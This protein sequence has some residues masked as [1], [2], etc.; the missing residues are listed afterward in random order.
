M[1]KISI[2]V[3]LGFFLFIEKGR[4]LFLVIYSHRRLFRRHLF[5]ANYSGAIHSSLFNGSSTLS[6][7]GDYSE[8]I[9]T[10]VSFWYNIL[11]LPFEVRVKEYLREDSLSTCGNHLWRKASKFDIPSSIF[12]NDKPDARRLTSSAY[13]EIPTRIFTIQ[14]S[15]QIVVMEV[16][17]L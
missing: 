9:Q 10:T 13:C 8:K 6:E 14:M 3:W 5:L 1:R 2:L 7:T 12:C 4:Y 11:R 16:K 17:L 15:W